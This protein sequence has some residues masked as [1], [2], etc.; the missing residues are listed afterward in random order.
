[1]FFYDVLS[2]YDVFLLFFYCSMFR[3]TKI[4]L[5]LYII[6]KCCFLFST[7]FFSQFLTVFPLS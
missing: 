7:I 6:F 2:S 3:Q 1:M 4:N 5:C